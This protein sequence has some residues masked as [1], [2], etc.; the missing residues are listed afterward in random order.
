MILP[1][2]CSL[3]SLRQGHHAKAFLWLNHI[4]LLSLSLSL[5][6]APR[7]HGHLC[8][9]SLWLTPHSIS[10]FSLSLSL[11]ATVTLGHELLWMADPIS[12]LCS[13]I[14]HVAVGWVSHSMRQHTHT[15]THTH[16]H[17]ALCKYMCVCVCVYVCFIDLHL[18]FSL[19]SL[20]LSHVAVGWVSHSMGHTHKAL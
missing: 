16:L 13:L 5:V 18:Y 1:S 17:K 19:C 3:L 10:H 12:S 2:L 9:Q 15:H 20:L 14:S 6:N 11:S 8:H 4:S 7:A